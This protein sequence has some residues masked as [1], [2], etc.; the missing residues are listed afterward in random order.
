MILR[1]RGVLAAKVA[2]VYNHVP[3]TASI[4]EVN[5][6]FAAL[7]AADPSPIG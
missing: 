3:S 7:C 4:I 1:K 2:N 6:D 5:N